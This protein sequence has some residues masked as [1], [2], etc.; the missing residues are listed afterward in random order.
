LS[1]NARLDTKFGLDF[2]GYPIVEFWQCPEL[3]FDFP[4][5]PKA[6]NGM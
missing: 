6:F 3:A 2:L 5:R 4:P 1:I